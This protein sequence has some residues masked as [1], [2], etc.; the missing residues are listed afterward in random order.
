MNLAEANRI[1]RLSDRQLAI[2][3]QAAVPLSPSAHD[4]YADEG[5]PYP[6]WASRQADIRSLFDHLFA[7]A[8][9]TSIR[10]SRRVGTA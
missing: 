10:R 1:L 6:P 5:G 2:V 8:S 3:R 7:V 9:M 4:R